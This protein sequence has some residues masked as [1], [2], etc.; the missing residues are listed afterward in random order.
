MLLKSGATVKLTR[1]DD[2]YVSLD[3]RK[4][5]G[6]A[7]ISIHNDSLDSPNA[8]GATVYWYK[9]NQ[10]ALAETLN[11]NI[12][13]KAMLFNRELDKRTSKYSDKPISQPYY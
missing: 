7:Y 11:T 4:L 2:T 8:N 5:N 9:N 12:Q 6:D 10:E 1:S 13:K 3:D